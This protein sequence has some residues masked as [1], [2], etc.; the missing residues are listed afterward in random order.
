VILTTTALTGGH[1]AFSSS[2]LLND[3]VGWILHSALLNPYFSWKSTHRRHHIY[4]NN[5][6]KD[7]NYVPPVAHSYASALGVKLEELAD[8]GEDAPIV[9]L[10][11]IILQQAI[12]WNWYI[13]TNI[14]AS[15]GAQL[16][17]GMS[18]WRQSHFDPWG[19][20]FRDS[21]VWSIILSDIGCLLT[22]TV[23]LW[24]YKYL[25]SF[26]HVFWLYIVPWTFVNHWIGMSL[27]HFFF[28]ATDSHPQVMITYLHHTHPSVPK[29]TSENWTFI[30]G[31]LATIDRDFGIIG[32]HFFHHISSDHVAHHLFSKIPHYYSREATEAIKPLLGKYCHGNGG[33]SWTELKLAF[34]KCQYVTED[35]GRSE[36]LFRDEKVEALWYKGGVSPAVEMKA[37]EGV[38][39][40]SVK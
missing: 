10:V 36:D 22:I 17:P 34:S 39:V 31:A 9:L 2:S 40:D 27:S 1:S 26:E 21:E 11:R 37:R 14:T 12:G 30:L 23:N 25:G 5:L 29:Y 28:I 18:A 33:F 19:S 7:H 38:I 3:T 13:L 20:L 32:T 16:K 35:A 6:S 15:P 4:A 8:L 24:L